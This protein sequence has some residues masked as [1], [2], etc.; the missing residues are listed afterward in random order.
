M[1]NKKPLVIVDG[2]RTP[3]SKMGTSLAAFDAVELGV[4]VVTHLLTKTGIDPELI[5]ET[6]FGCVSQ[7]AEAANIARVIALR[8]GIPR[9]KPAMT[10]HRNCASGLES[11]TTASD[12]MAAG[13]GEVFIVGGTESM[14]RIPLYYSYQ[15]AGKFAQLAR[16]RGTMAKLSAMA[17]FRPADFKPI[18]GLMMGL[19]DP[20]AGMNMGQT[21][22]LLAREFDITR[23]QQD[24]FALESHNKAEAAAEQLKEEMCPVYTDANKDGFVLGDNGVRKGQTIAALQKLKPI[25][26]RKT[27]TVTAGNSSQITDGAC[28]LLVMTEERAQKLSMQPLGRLVDHAYAGCDPERMG[29]GPAYAIQRMAK[30]S[31][32][33]P[34]DASVVEINEAFST[35]VLAV[36]KLLRDMRLTIPP[37]TLNPLGGAVALGHPVGASG[38]RLV[39]TALKQLHHDGGERALISLCIGGGQGG[40]AWLEKI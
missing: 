33:K 9:E 29:L 11:M 39:L 6:I 4:A 27:G 17:A 24:Q 5:D 19:T 21:A 16:A 40:A 38:A 12:R 30:S 28:A 31:G 2:V 36:E 8:S 20:V 32:L 34:K 15:A 23:E 22:E 13:H 37:K 25:F 10:V 1:K 26:E 18:P 7:P 3:F 14:S 35:Q